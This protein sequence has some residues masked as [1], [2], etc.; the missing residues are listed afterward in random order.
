MSAATSS[1]ATAKI[2]EA[3]APAHTPGRG[4]IYDSIAEAYG[5]TPLVRLNRLPGLNGVKATILAKLE[6]FNPASSVKDRIGAAMVAALEREGIIKPD[7]VLIDPNATAATVE[8]FLRHDARDPAGHLERHGATAVEQQL[9]D[10]H[11]YPDELL[12]G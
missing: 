2:A 12:A 11:Q 8:L 4:R 7:T 5:D 1:A 3:P 10:Q 6:Y 9:H